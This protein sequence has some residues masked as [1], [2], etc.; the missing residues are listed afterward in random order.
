MTDVIGRDAELVEVQTFLDSPAHGLRALVLDGDAGI[1]KSTLWLAGVEAARG[2]SLRVL[3]SRPAETE[4]SLAHVVL[5]DL[6]GEV[7]SDVIDALPAPRRRA[8]EA[9]LLREEPDHPVDPRA[10]GVAIHT[11]LSVVAQEGPLVLAIDDDQWMDASSAATLEFALRR[12]LDLPIVLLLARRTDTSPTI[13]LE[14]VMDPGQ[15]ELLHIGPLSVGAIQLLL[16]RQT[17]STFP[18]LVLVRLHEASGGNPFYALELARVRAESPSRDVGE[19]WAMP[20]TLERLV[21][22]RLD[23]LDVSTRVPLLLVAAAGRLPI[24]LLSA[25]G[26]APEAL[27]PARAANVIDIHAGTI[28]FTHPL[29]AS[30][31]YDAAKAEE[32][33]SA[34]RHLATVL[35]DPLERA[36]H[37]A[38]GTEGQDES[39]AQLLD[40]AALEARVR[41]M[42][43]AGAELAE[44]AARLTPS[45]APDDRERRAIQS[46]WAHIAAG[47]GTV[48]QSIAREVIRRRPSGRWRAE[49]LFL[50][51]PDDDPAEAIDMLREALKEAAAAPELRVRIHADL[52]RGGRFIRGPAWTDLHARASLRLAERV[53]DDALRAE[54]LTAVATHGFNVGDPRA[55]DLAIEANRI[56]ESL[57]NPAL[58]NTTGW[59]V[60]NILSWSGVPARARAWL[61]SQL[62]ALG[63]HDEDARGDRLFYLSLVEL[64]AGRWRLASEYARESREITLQYSGEIPHDLLVPA[65]IALHRGELHVAR[66]RSRRAMILGEGQLLPNH[67]AILAICELWDG[68]SEEALASFIEAEQTAD[69][70]G[71]H[72]PFMRW[73]RTEFAEALLRLGRI[74]EAD[75]LIHEWEAAATKLGRDWTVAQAIR[76]RGAIAAARGDLSAAVALLERAVEQHQEVGDPFGRGRALLALGVVN[77][78]RRQKRAARTALDAALDA[79]ESLGA[80]GWAAATRTELA[81]VGGRTRIEGLS[82]SERRV[83]VLVAEGRTNREIASSLF[84]GERTVASHLTH[85]YSKLGIRSRTELA[86]QLLPLPDVSPED[87][88]NSPTS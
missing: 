12:S 72:E 77:L 11:L 34:H 2:R 30:G 86:R 26:I 58:L 19:P 78:R 24:D 62:E 18:R 70:S 40:A 14:H 63:D 56:A 23:R 73:W 57:A 83:A 35:D 15:V 13:A 82:P 68:R 55:L 3:T 25:L 7:G 46:A 75:R 74:D 79:F 38:L 88:S 16:A 8:L 87:A 28:R 29:L 4:Q 17:A 9:A 27:G 65:L 84:L 71:L 49:A 44:H 22:G 33:R 51:R 80:D 64:W 5:G 45:D 39:I 37:L 69:A 20:P 41:G 76:G 67:P 32:R 6:F 43:M 52:A 61:A 54:A 81:R 66:E 59:A 10:L 1:G 48:A 53:G 47:S 60:S 21:A 85:I 42:A 36:Q 50:L 31:L